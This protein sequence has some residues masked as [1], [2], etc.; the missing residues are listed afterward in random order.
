LG[1]NVVASESL[2]KQH[3]PPLWGLG[4]RD[5]GCIE[6]MTAY[7]KQIID[8]TTI[9]YT[10]E[11]SSSWEQDEEELPHQSLFIGVIVLSMIRNLHCVINTNTT[12]RN[13]IVPVE[14]VESYIEHISF[15][16]HFI[17]LDNLILGK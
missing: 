4:K 8:F 7:D 12:T 13:Y 6:Y 1:T 2:Q 15:I 5:A 10:K 14:I 11:Y 9:F 16:L 17:A 3:K